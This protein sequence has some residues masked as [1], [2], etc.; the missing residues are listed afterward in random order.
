MRD[1]L[2]CAMVLLVLAMAL[3]PVGASPA[4]LQQLFQDY[5][6]YQ[7]AENP[8]LATSAGD[9]RAN[10]RLPSVTVA[11]L[12]RR[13]AADRE[14][15]ARLR[16][17]DRTALPADER[18]SY[19]VLARKLDESIADFEFGAWRCSLTADWGYH[20]DFSQLPANVPLA[21]TKDYE[22]YVARLRDF[23]R[24]NREQIALLREGLRTGFTLPRVVLAGYDG[25][26]SAHVVRDPEAS[27]F[28]A[29]FRAFPAEIPEAD[30]VRLTRDGRAAI[31]D[32]VVPAYR[33]LLEFFT[34]EYIPGARTTTGAS[35]LPDGKRYYAH[36]VRAF[37]TLD[38]T[39]EEVHAI[40]L[41]EVARIRA[42][43]EAVIKQT[44]FTGSFAEFLRFLRTD[45][46]FYAKT[47]DELLK[48][49]SFI[50]KRM[51]GKLPTLFGRLP[52]LSY[53]VAPVPPDIAPKF[54]GGRYI[55]APL[56]GSRAG[57]YWVNTSSLSSRPLYV[58]EALTMH[59]AVPGHHLQ[60]ALQHELTGLPEFRRTAGFDAFVEGW[61]LYSERLGLEAG[62]Y[63]DPYSNFGRLTYEMWRACRLVVDTGIHDMGWSRDRALQFLGENTALSEHEVRTE[64]D[65]YI[66]WPGQALAYKMG[67]LKIRELRQRA[68]REL[69]PRF[70]LRAFHDAVLANGAIPL[71]VL[72][73]RIG[74]FIASRSGR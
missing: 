21:T 43:M 32:A 39:P 14:F 9:S 13:N 16:A 41:R 44:G 49:A 31:V 34:K 20:M 12:T 67:E 37:T 64:I 45:P 27:V 3:V 22:N 57:F 58:L 5:W 8:L 65:R 26:V 36:R 51:D 1:I 61:A 50:A 11:D 15:L 46:R 6:E 48:E 68:E 55:E 4:P 69:G 10:D 28:Y 59:E 70:D 2:A 56:D 33:E 52:R 35:D 74:A 54:T 17:I 53:G 47:P 7:L 71:S 73:D 18:V 62:F 42:E 24:Y 66:S 72:D 25:T 23:P 38:V 29:P 30:R 19:D 40:G 63:Q 60:I